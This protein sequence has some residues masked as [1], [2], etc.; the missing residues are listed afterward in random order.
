MNFRRYQE[1]DWPAL[2]PILQATFAAGDT[3]VFPR[4]MPEA[5]ARQAWTAVPDEVWLAEDEQ[6]RVLGSG[7]L[8]PNQPGQGRHIANAGFVVSE[9]ARG[10]GVARQLAGHVVDRAKAQGFAGM[11]FN[12]VVS[13]N[14]AAVHLWQDMGFQIVGTLP[15]AFRHP[16]L[17]EVDAYVMFQRW[18][19]Q[20]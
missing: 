12:M 20:D 17:G 3:Y 18:A 4:D 7:Y 5:A 16:R 6:G 10:Q 1:A 9:H 11:Q 15:G 2:W 19:V 13:S 8:K 14:H